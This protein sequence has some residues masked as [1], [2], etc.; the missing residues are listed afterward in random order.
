MIITGDLNCR[1][2][3]WWEGDIDNEEGISLEPLTTDIGLYQMIT[4]PTHF[5]GSSRS[6]VDL[7][8]TDQPNIFLETGVHPSLNEQCHHQIIYGKLA[9]NNPSPASHNRRLWFYDG[10][11]VSAI[12]KSIEM[13]NWHKCL[14][15]LTVRMNK[16]TY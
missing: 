13:Y 4:E 11:N 5:M 14:L 8:L 12:R 10:A 15:R 1:S 7:V 2:T 6:C 3:N 9:I 16:S